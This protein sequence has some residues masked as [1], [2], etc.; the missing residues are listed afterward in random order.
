MPLPVWLRRHRLEVLLFAFR[1]G[2]PV[3]PDALTAVLGAK[4]ARDDEPFAQWT[5]HGVRA[6]LWHE[7]VEWCATSGLPAPPAV[8][9]TMWTVLDHQLAAEGFGPGSDP[10]EVLRAPLLDSGGLGPDG[11]PR[12]RRGS[13]HRHPSSRRAG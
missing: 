1:A 3:H 6:L 12:A 4:H 9:E 5:Q 13:R 2:R 11:R 8:A 7:V 10:I